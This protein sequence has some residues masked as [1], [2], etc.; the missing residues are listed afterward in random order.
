MSALGAVTKTVNLK[1]KSSPQ[2]VY[3]AAFS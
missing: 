1:G 2:T 3:V